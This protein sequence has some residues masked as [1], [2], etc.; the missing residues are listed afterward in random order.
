MWLPVHILIGF[1]IT[2]WI[3]GRVR[4]TGRFG[5]VKAWRH[6][7]FFPEGVWH[8]SWILGP[9]SIW[10]ENPLGV[11]RLL[12]ISCGNSLHRSVINYTMCCNTTWEEFNRH[13][14]RDFWSA[15][16][17]QALPAALFRQRGV[18][19]YPSCVPVPCS[20]SERSQRQRVCDKCPEATCSP[21]WS[22]PQR[23]SCFLLNMPQTRSHLQKLKC[24]I[25]SQEGLGELLD[26]QHLPDPGSSPSCPGKDLGSP[27]DR[28]LEMQRPQQRAKHQIC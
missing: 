20:M 25:Q 23:P 10:G 15:W 18:D 3:F 4:N 12:H 8:F 9:G 17:R 6:P 16:R 21:A 5:I 7:D 28:F 11:S 26:S 24:L 13:R 22:R 1:V 14:K 2:C 19:T 27:T